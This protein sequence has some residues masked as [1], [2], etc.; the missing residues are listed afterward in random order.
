MASDA[1]SKERHSI[2]A[3]R[4]THAQPPDHLTPTAILTQELAQLLAAAIAQRQAARGQPGAMP[5]GSELASLASLV[6]GA[7]NQ[8]SLAPVFKDGLSALSYA[9]SPLAAPAPL[10]QTEMHHD[11]EPM[12]IPSTWRQPTRN[13]EDRWFRQQ[14]GAT[15]LGL[16]A[17]LIVVVPAV[18]WLSGRLGGAPKF[19]PASVAQT[20]SVSKET[21][22]S[23]LKTVKVQVRTVERA[24]EIAAQYVTGSINSH[25]AGE[26]ARAT[27]AAAVVK[28][29]ENHS[30]AEDLLAQA[31]QRIEGGD[32]V[33][34]REVLTAAETKAG[35][36]GP[37]WFALAETYD[38][39]MLAAWGTRGVS[40]DVARAKALYNKAFEVGVAR[41]RMRLDA[42][43]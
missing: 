13:D 22:S 28:A 35:M 33:G 42:L 2:D 21:K 27:P 16:I 26:P 12:P 31:K 40:A 30:R 7:A 1:S 41:A 38:P 20:A 37:M 43:R 34:A 18:L 6:S 32:V 24:G 11:D 4:G 23:E 19:G 15:L 9:P 39:N 3:G 29:A 10:S 25:T 14:M 17:G 8:R 5:T 36:N